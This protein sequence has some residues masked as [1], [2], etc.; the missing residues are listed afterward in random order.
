M[1]ST[2]ITE[3]STTT[4]NVLC[5]SM[6]SPE[7]N[8]SAEGPKPED[9][10]DVTSPEPVVQPVSESSSDTGVGYSL[11]KW[12][13]RDGGQRKPSFRTVSFC[14]IFKILLI[15]QRNNTFCLCALC[16]HTRTNKNENNLFPTMEA[17]PRRLSAICKF[18]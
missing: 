11:H 15:E 8:A 5:S 1:A 13:K 3:A 12:P 14:P 10:A 7:L 2:P 4:T 6:S 17:T 16:L 18:P 9:S